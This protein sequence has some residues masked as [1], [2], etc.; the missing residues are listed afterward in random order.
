MCSSDREFLEWRFRTLDP[1][2]HSPGFLGYSCGVEARDV[3]GVLLRGHR[4]H[5]G[6]WMHVNPSTGLTI[7]GTINQA[8]RRPD[9]VVA[10]AVAAALEA[11]LVERDH[12]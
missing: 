1:A 10:G 5:W 8:N 6:G 11:G 7:T 2:N 9:R 4:G 12:Q 3:H